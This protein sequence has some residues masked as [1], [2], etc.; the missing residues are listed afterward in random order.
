MKKLILSNRLISALFIDVYQPASRIAYLQTKDTP[1][2][3]EWILSGGCRKNIF[4]FVA[5]RNDAERRPLCLFS[6]YFVETCVR[7]NLFP[8]LC[9]HKQNLQ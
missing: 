6:E 2:S 5:Y 8:Y 9:M 3:K 1:V 4:T 7:L